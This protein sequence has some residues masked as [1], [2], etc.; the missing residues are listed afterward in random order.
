MKT[1][2]PLTLL[3][4]LLPL[5]CAALDSD[6]EQ[7]IEVE[8]Y[9]LEVRE[10]ENISI[11]EGNV[12]LIQGSLNILSERLIIHFNDANELTLMEMTGKPAKLRQLDNA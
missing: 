2:N 12:T 8:A 1:V 6:R 4:F 10:L 3:L 9:H 5:H 11:Y 7:P